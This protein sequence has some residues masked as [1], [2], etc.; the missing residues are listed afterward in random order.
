MRLTRRLLIPTLVFVGL[1]LVGLITYNVAV[2]VRQTDEAE[3]ERLENMNDVFLARLGATENLA[4]ALASEVANNPEV[5]A[6]FAHRDRERLIELTLPSYQVIDAQFDIP[7]YQFHLAPATS[8]LRL[9]NLEQYGDDLSS[10]R[11]TVLA[12]NAEKRAISGLE[13]G[14]G[15]LGIRGVVPVTYHGRHIG[16]V[17]FGPNV[18][19]PLIEEMKSEFGYEWQILLSRGPAE[20]AT[21]EGV[22]G[23]A[24][25]PINELLLQASTLN[26]PIFASVTNYTQA[27]AGD[28]SVEHIAVDDREYAVLSAPLY[29]FSGNVIGVVDILSDHTVIAQQQTKQVLLSVGILLIILL[30]VGLGISFITGRLLQPIGDLT[31][32]ASAI[33][34]GDFSRRTDIKSTDELGILAQAFNSM[35]SQLQELFGNLEQRVAD[36]TRALAISADVTRRLAAILDPRQLISEVVEQ[37]QSAFNYYYAQIYLLDEAGENLVIAGGTGEAG[38]SMLARKHS[39]PKGRGLV[40][41]AADANASVLVPDVSQED[42]WLPNELLPETKA[43][44][45]IPI[46]I[47]NQVMGVLDV[48]HSRV[49]GL[50]TDDVTLL[51]SLA[52]QVAISLQNARS[53]ERSRKQGEFESLVNMIGQRIQRTTSIEDTLQ[54]AIREL[55]TAIGASRVKASIR[56]TSHDGTPETVGF[57]VQHMRED[58]NGNDSINPGASSND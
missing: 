51:E 8:F 24:D 9:H 29:D 6:A 23:E 13:I 39:V 16:T 11:S 34:A 18:D 52:G 4:V 43:E 15:G 31:A 3:R 50:T 32:V 55:G 56:Q 57:V 30:V 7:Q 36:R 26:T 27:L 53:Y 48:Q 12:A 58:A 49:N 33:S 44:A 2:S 5:Q 1:I 10:F 42:G 14:R 40:G 19:L 47:G 25:G 38:A 35:V 46:S 37:I 28:V 41:R 22:M 20:V 17:E 45:S 54:T 21:F